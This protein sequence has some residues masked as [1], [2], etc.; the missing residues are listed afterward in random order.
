[1]RQKMVKLESLV[2]T[3][4]CSS[5][6]LWFRVLRLG[7]NVAWRGVGRKKNSP[8]SLGGVSREYWRGGD[9]E[10]FDAEVGLQ[11]SLIQFLS[12]LLQP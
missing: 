8:Q 12:C 10:G 5:H 9:Q 2:T 6:W 3:K 1:M 4:H 11:A 7:L